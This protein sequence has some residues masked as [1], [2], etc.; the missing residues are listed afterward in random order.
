MDLAIIS[1][2]KWMEGTIF[3]I[4]IALPCHA[5]ADPTSRWL[6]R[7][8]YAVIPTNKHHM[9]SNMSHFLS[10]PVCIPNRYT[11]T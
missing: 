10:D 4:G 5:K 7:K 3:S 8:E 2:A 9:V 6:A 1:R 11:L